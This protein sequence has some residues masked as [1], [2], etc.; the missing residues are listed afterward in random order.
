MGYGLQEWAQNVKH[1]YLTPRRRQVLAAICLVAHDDHGLYWMGGERLIEERLQDL[2]YGTYRNILSKLVEYGLLIKVARGG[3]RTSGGRGK[4]YKY[5][6]N[7]PIVRNSQP[8]QSVLPEIVRSPEALPA[9]TDE[10][11]EMPATSM[12]GVYQ[13][14]QDLLDMGFTPDQMSMILD[15]VAGAIPDISD[16]ETGPRDAKHVTEDDMQTRN[17]SPRMTSKGDKSEKHVTQNDMQSGYMSSPVTCI[18]ENPRPEIKKHVTLSDKNQG[19]MSLSVTPHLLVEDKEGE[20][21]E[22]AAAANMSPGYETEVSFFSLLVKALGQAGH[23]GIRPAQFDHLR[24]LVPKY[25]EATGGVLPDESTADYIVGRL[26]ASKGVR[27]VTGFVLSV[28][29]D[30]LRTGE[31]YEEPGPARA[32]PSELP[33]I[34][35]DP[36]PEPDW[37]LIHLAHLEQVAPAQEVWASALERLRTEVSRPAFETWLAESRGVAYVEGTFVVGIAN[38]FAAEMLEHRLHPVIERVVRYVTDSVLS[39]EYAVQARD[40]ET[41]PVCEGAADVSAAAS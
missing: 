30:V 26:K 15:T 10:S 16:A 9:E 1:P 8:E 33:E 39:I 25:S 3:G 11:S 6:V 17:M 5:R 29:E 13:K 18:D 32:S 38:R 14:L 19:N 2:S 36:D 34:E 22:E 31:G 40:D 23:R 20:D 27:N 4:P 7:S 21:K 12:S 35:I 37:E 41:C 24:E 28:T